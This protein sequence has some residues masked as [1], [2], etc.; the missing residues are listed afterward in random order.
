MRVYALS[1]AAAAIIAGAAYV[2]LN[3]FQE[4]TAD[5]YTTGSARLDWQEQS[6]SY[7]F[8]VPPPKGEAN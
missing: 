4:S 2:S 5:A 3:S 7:G 6:N 1:V 8:Q